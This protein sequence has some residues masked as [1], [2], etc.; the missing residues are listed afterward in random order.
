[1]NIEQLQAFLGWCAVL[2]YGV[3]LFATVMLLGFRNYFKQLCST[4]YKIDSAE[5]E[6][7]YFQFLAA[8]K[9]LTIIFNIVPYIVL[10]FMF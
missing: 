6:K 9:G 2:N 4:V 3:L 7:I 10:R 8:Y 1:M 5:F